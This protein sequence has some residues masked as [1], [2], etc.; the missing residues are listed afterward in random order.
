VTP[1]QEKTVAALLSEPSIDRAAKAAGV[2][3]RSVYRWLKEDGEFASS[4]A[5]A[6][7]QAVQHAAG[8]L[9]RHAAVFAGVLLKVATKEDA[10]EA[11]RVSAAVKGLEFAFR[12]S[13]DNLA[14]R[15]AQVEATLAELASRNGRVV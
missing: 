3:A 11:S 6:R 4:Y 13:D 5:A 12:A 8:L 14:E 1:T 2:S 9:Q 7:R 15:L 10:P